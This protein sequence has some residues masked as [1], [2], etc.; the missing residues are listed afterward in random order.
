[1]MKTR[2]SEKNLIWEILKKLNKDETK[3][4]SIGNNITFNLKH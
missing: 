2:Q 3:V 1:M 4:R